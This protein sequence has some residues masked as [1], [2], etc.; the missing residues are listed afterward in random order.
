MAHNIR[1]PKERCLTTNETLTSFENWRQT[2]IYSASLNTSFAPFLRSNIK[3]SKKT[4]A[5]DNRGLTDEGEGDAKQTAVQRAAALE[6]L[7]GYIANYAPVI[8]RSTITKNCT[9]L[10]SIWQALREHYGF[11]NTGA[12][13]LDLSQIQREPNERPEDLYQRLLAFVDDNL[14]KTGSG[15]QHHGEEPTEDEEMS[16]SLEN[17]TVYLWLQLIHQQ[18]PKL[19]KQRYA[20]SLRSKT[21]ASIKPEISGA[22][23]SLLEEIASNEEAKVFK[24]FSQNYN[25]SRNRPRPTQRPTQTN[26]SCPLCKEAGRDHT[27]YLSVCE[28]LP[29]KDKQYLTRARIVLSNDDAAADETDTEDYAPTNL[30]TSTRRV[31]VSK[32][33]EFKAYYH[34]H[35][36]RITLDS[37]AETNMIKASLAKYLGVRVTPSTQSALQADGVTQ[38]AVLGETH[39]TVTRDNIQLK[40]DALVVEELDVDVLGGTPFLCVNDISIKFAHSQIIIG[41]RTL[42]TYGSQSK[43]AHSSIRRTQLVR[44]PAESSVIWPGDYIDIPIPDTLCDSELVIEP[45]F[46]NTKSTAHQWILPDVIEAVGSNI[47]L[48]NSSNQPQKLLKNEQFCQVLPVVQDPVLPEGLEPVF[49]HPKP[50]SPISKVS[51]DPDKILPIDCTNKHLQLLSEFRD[52]FSSNITGYNGNKGPFQCTVNMGPALPPQRKG[53][54]P[55][56]SRNKLLELQAQFDELEAVGVFKRPEDIGI[57]AEYLNPSFLVKKPNGGS[58]LVTAFSEVAKYCK[59]QP[60]LMTDVDTTL[61]MIAQWKYII[62]SDLSKAF[63]QIPLNRESM[64]FCGVATPFRGIRV[65]TRCAMGMP[66]SETALEELMCRVFGDLL[67]EGRVAKLADDL[68]CGGDTPDEVLH[69]WRRVLKAL[70]ECNLKLSPS[71]TIICPRKTTILGW[72]WCDGSLSAS[73]H[74]LSTLT[75]CQPPSTVK[76][77]RSFIGAYKS[78]ARVLPNCAQL[79]SP[80]DESIAGMTSKDQ[81]PWTESLKDSFLV[82]QKNLNNHKS[83]S[84]PRP[85]DHL[86]IITDGSTKMSGIGATLYINRN[87]SFLLAGFYSA[88]IRQHQVKW[89]PCEV[90]ALGIGAAI[91]HFSP[92]IIQSVHRTSVY[93]DSKPCMQAYQRLQRGEFSISPRVT[94][95][96]T[97]AHRHSVDIHHLAGSANVPSDFASRNAPQCEEDRCQICCFLRET[98]VSTIRLTNASDIIQGRNRLPYA[99]RA[100]WRASQMEDPDLRRTHAHMSQGTRPSKK[101]TDIKDVKRYLAQTSLASDGLLVVRRPTPLSPNTE[102]IV[103]PRKLTHGLLTALHLKLDHPTKHQLRQT[104]RRQ[105]FA[106]DMD[107]LIDEVS[108]SCHMCASL[109]CIPKHLNEQ[110]TGDPP[111]AVG[112]SFA[113]DIIKRCRQLIFVLRECSTS[114]TRSLLI[115]NEQANSI[116]TALVSL[117]LDIRPM[118]GPMAVVRVDPGPGFIA[119]QN[120]T[121]LSSINVQLEIGRAKNENKNPVAE[122]AVRELE[123][124]I[125]RQQPNGGPVSETTL[126]LATARLNSRIRNRGLSAREMLFQRNQCTN[127]QIPMSDANL[128]KEQHQHRMS[129]HH[130]SMISKGGSN[131]LLSSST[132]KVGDIVYLYKDRDK[133]K[134]R[135]RYIVTSIDGQWCN[136]RKFSG[137]QLRASSYKV[138]LVE[139]YAVPPY[140]FRDNVL[141]HYD[142]TDDHFDVIEDIVPVEPVPAMESFEMTNPRASAPYNPASNDTTN[143]PTECDSSSPLPHDPASVEATNISTDYDSG[144]PPSYD[145]VD[146]RPS[147]TRKLPK[148]FNDYLMG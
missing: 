8:S 56:Y 114:Y 37:G 76:G 4:K 2:L 52:V 70:Q 93:T 64:K 148:R 13:F 22:L 141:T 119:L 126:S 34:Q 44:A 47:R 90:E 3:W 133:T 113:A 110:S 117:C 46:D 41:D 39:F 139:C 29:E 97:A 53:R 137:S 132:I 101:S 73:P 67:Q 19:V 11:N 27:H 125:A 135:D 89:L 108:E 91:K 55:L 104:V 95:F 10:E 57:V 71:K 66:G 131:P 87:G 116:R 30:G 81:I 145:T 40:L 82:A 100:A 122:K 111:E 23:D 50:D 83:I 51:V 48:V 105:F 79:M 60:S 25:K 99:S 78:L 28:F 92:Y 128:I 35:P 18:L 124:E 9:S 85:T 61:R 43:L 74:R 88:K 69:N 130:H 86:V 123:D 109:K 12:H 33:P 59:P 54:M 75:T 121:T 20:T 49:T 24:S 134:S 32:S 5:A 147:R 7:L 31:N 16:P 77:L 138:K 62:T 15:I 68:Y 14:M 1:A 36:V 58:R 21:L 42:L 106:L 112:V 129:N 103:I 102:A 143:M 140:K 107:R 115:P 63:Y 65:Y 144:S 84:L 142:S 45:R 6:L 127:E 94:T 118:E 136:I 17:M 26:K 146:H 80:L 38:L 98:E 120:D 72:I 96:L